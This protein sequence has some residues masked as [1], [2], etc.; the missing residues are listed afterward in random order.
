M[1]NRCRS[2]SGFQRKPNHGS[3]LMLVLIVVAVVSILALMIANMSSGERTMIEKS[4]KVCKTQNLFDSFMKV[5]IPIIRG[6]LKDTNSAMYKSLYLELVKKQADFTASSSFVIDIKND[7]FFN[8]G[9]DPVS[10]AQRKTLLD[11]LLRE[12][13]G[14][15]ALKQ[16][17]LEI[18]INPSNFSY[19]TNA[20]FQ[21]D[22]EKFGS[23]VL[24]LTVDLNGEVFSQQF[25][26]D[27]KVTC[28][29]PELLGKFNF[30]LRD[31]LASNIAYPNMEDR[32]NRF[33]IFINAPDASKLT[34]QSNVFF[35]TNGDSHKNGPK[36]LA[37]GGGDPTDTAPSQKKLAD[38][39]INSYG[40]IY[41]G[42]HYQNN[43]SELYLR[44]T[45]GEYNINASED[46]LF[47]MQ[48][49][50]FNKNDPQ[51]PERMY[52]DG[53]FNHDY[54]EIRCWKMGVCSL[55]GTKYHKFFTSYYDA[56]EDAFNSSFLHLFGQPD[57]VSPTLVLGKV[58]TV[59]LKF[60]GAV[61]NETKLNADPTLTARIG[62]I[63][64][65]L[66]TGTANS[67]PW[68]ALPYFYDNSAFTGNTA[69]SVS[70]ADKSTFEFFMEDI[71]TPYASVNGFP[72]ITMHN[73]NEYTPFMSNFFF[74]MFNENIDYIITG[75]YFR[76]P[77]KTLPERFYYRHDEDIHLAPPE[78]LPL[79]NPKVFLYNVLKNQQEIDNFL[80][81][82]VAWDFQSLDFMSS[83]SSKGLL[84]VRPNT[85]PVENVLTLDGIIQF[86]G[87]ITLENIFVERGGMIITDGDIIL[88]GDI[89]LRGSY[90]KQDA[91][92]L[93]VLY[94][95]NGNIKVKTKNGR[96]EIYASL[97]APNGTVETDGILS[98]FGNMVVDHL[99]FR[100]GSYITGIAKYG[101]TL[102]YNPSLGILPSNKDYDKTFMLSF[103]EAI[104][105]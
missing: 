46:F 69:N 7:I 24:L 60:S 53:N 23:L 90:S 36:W 99:Y 5:I 64:G 48:D 49:P 52:K 63:N 78:F 18:K 31:A 62:T 67:F 21:E 56:N 40:W 103:N 41:L 58:Q 83:L 104:Y 25:F 39:I 72:S 91:N 29:I 61:L 32:K 80:L 27:V 22:R 47:Y 20:Y 70:A 8:S 75:N 77:S 35:L 1:N 85:Q 3:A 87:D 45:Y 73:L 10:Q 102:D 15:K 11:N 94:T 93:L 59:G 74:K 13:G 82:K 71:N 9:A 19:Y 65:T 42:T 17:D 81:P 105:R 43:P 16:L 88:K 26:C 4:L 86:K 37:W 38:E 28:R 51:N 6:E 101:G 12:Y 33:N 55:K 68:T 96:S 66:P 14:E 50:N 100:S 57:K 79:K 2:L 98:I 95:T 92:S 34:N 30:L 89:T 76:E 44:A 54:W 84:Y 97:M